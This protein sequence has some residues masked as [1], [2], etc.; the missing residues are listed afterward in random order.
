ML[1]S[2]LRNRNKTI[3]DIT[4]NADEHWK[5]TYESSTD[6]NQEKI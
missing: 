2:G 5:K 3:F 6:T 1:Q 4:Q